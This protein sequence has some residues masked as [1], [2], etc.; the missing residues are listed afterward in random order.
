VQSE[1][2]AKLHML[3]ELACILAIDKPKNAR[4]RVALAHAR[5]R[6]EANSPR[7]KSHRATMKPRQRANIRI[8]KLRTEPYE[9]W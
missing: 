2:A 3:R 7:G 9:A 1:H 5:A 6:N 4:A 8:K